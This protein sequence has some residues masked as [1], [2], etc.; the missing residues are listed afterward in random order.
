MRH[1]LTAIPVL[2][3]VLV[4]AAC[5]A[6]DS[7]VSGAAAAPTEAASDVGSSPTAPAVTE[8]EGTWTTDLT[9]KAV[10]AYIR[11][12]GWGEQAEEFLL[13]PDMAG[14]EQTQFRVDFVGDRFRM[15]QVATDEQWQ[16]GTFRIE[17]GRIYLDDE[18]PVGELTFAVHLDGDVL[19][20]DS[21]GD[22][23]GGGQFIPGV[24]GW[25]PGAVMWASTTWSR[26]EG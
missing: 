15:A 4:L 25:A 13:A 24:P 2:T 14:P 22:T 21:P 20:Y 26:A 8:L 17:D 18:A 5:G 6:D 19:T 1:H 7:S 16:S 23:G 9:R 10:R 12:Q 11:G 3:A